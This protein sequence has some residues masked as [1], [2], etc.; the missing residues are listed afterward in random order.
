MPSTI[1]ASTTDAGG[2]GTGTARPG[3]YRAPAL[4]AQQGLFESTPA[5]K[6]AGQT[7][8]GEF[9]SKRANCPAKDL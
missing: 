8:E 9:A 6:A 2:N 7:H 5:A 1:A 3:V 4:V